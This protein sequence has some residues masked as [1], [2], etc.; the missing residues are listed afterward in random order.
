MNRLRLL[1]LTL[2][3]ANVPVATVPDAGSRAFGYG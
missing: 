3:G 1:H 2:W